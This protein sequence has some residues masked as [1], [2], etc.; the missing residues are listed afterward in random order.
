MMVEL[1]NADLNKL[2]FH[3]QGRYELVYTAFSSCSRYLAIDDP[4]KVAS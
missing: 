1:K 4:L 3:A 2:D